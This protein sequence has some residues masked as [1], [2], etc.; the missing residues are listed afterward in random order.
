MRLH[1]VNKRGLF[2]LKHLLLIGMVMVLG[3]AT[4]HAEVVSVGCTGAPGPGP[5]TT[6]PLRLPLLHSIPTYP[7]T[8]TL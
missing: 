8:S 4:A 6:Q 7:I 1:V 2:L 3:P 5:M